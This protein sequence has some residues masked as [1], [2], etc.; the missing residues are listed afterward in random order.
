MCGILGIL[1]TRPRPMLGPL[2]HRLGTTLRH[3]GPDDHGWLLAAGDALERG[4]SVPPGHDADVFLLHQRLSIL[5]L[6]DAGWQPMADPT[7]RWFLIF[8]GE[9]YNYL[10]LRA[11]LERCGHAFH[12][13][14]DSEVLLHAFLEWD[15][16]ALRRLVGMFAFAIFDVQAGRAFLA[17]DPFGIKP[18]YYARPEGAFVFASEIKALLGWPG[19]RRNVNAPQLYD[20]LRSGLTDHSELTLFAEVRQLP[21]GHFLEL[22]RTGNWAGAPEPYAAPLGGEPIDVSFDEAAEHVR[23]L[24]LDNVRLHLR[25]DVPVGAALSGGTDS[26]A[27]VAAMRAVAPDLEL[28]AFSYVADQPELSEER[29]IDVAARRAGAVLH[30]VH[31]SPDELVSDLDRLIHVQDEPFGGTSIYAQHRVFRAARENG[32]TV[33]LDGQGA[34][35]LLGGYRFYFISRLASLV[36]RG[37]LGRAWEFLQS[38]AAQPAAPGRARLAVHCAGSLLPA[39]LRAL[40][41]RAAGRERLPPWLN[42]RW[43]DERGAVVPARRQAR[44]LIEHLEQTLTE[45]SLPMLLRYEDRN[46]MA[47]SIESRVPFLTPALANYLLRLPED[48]L[49]GRDGTTKNV[50]RRAMRGLVPDEVLDRRDKIGFATPERQWMTQLG[51]WVDQTLRGEAARAI[52]ALDVQGMVAEWEAVQAGQRPFDARVWRW[53]NL[54]RWAERFDV[55]FG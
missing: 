26:S 14:G 7:G 29:W 55:E 10:E 24:F 51:P 22:S 5:D 52:G 18:L 42:A 36:R 1:T 15:Q 35:E 48:Y 44:S 54:I 11:E 34:D 4:R 20:Y 21:A 47:Y 16:A 43:F 31:P 3:R 41:L 46:S 25:S 6:S 23:A 30:K 50:F 12:S 9:I 8:N 53:V 17:R 38:A 28:H 13:T 49:I 33:M 40:S 32:V 2:G 19:L 27:I 45:T 37:G 39:G